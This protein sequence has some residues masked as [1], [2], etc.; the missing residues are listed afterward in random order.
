M[1]SKTRTATSSPLRL[2][3]NASPTSRRSHALNRGA[4]SSIEGYQRPEVI[5]HIDAI[6]QYIESEDAIVPSA[7]VI[8]FDDRVTFE[9]D[10]NATDVGYSTPGTIVIPIDPAAPES[11]RPGWIVDGQQRTAAIRDARVESFPISVVAFV[12]QSDAEQRAQFILVNAT[13]PLSKSLIYE[14]L[15]ATEG[16]LPEQLLRRQLPS[17][18]VERLNYDEDS[19]L[20]GM[21]NTPTTPDGIVKDNSML[22]M[23]ENSIT[24]GALYRFR[25]PETGEGDLDEMLTVL[26]PFWAA[27]RE[28]FPDAWGFTDSQVTPHARCRC[29]KPGLPYGCNCRSVLRRRFRPGG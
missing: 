11:D 8:A 15:P 22:R 19:P 1:F 20:A 29:R 16:E 4:T 23:L 2:T 9:P 27:V 24:D 6:R 26:K 14:L 25:N 13:K 21:I 12:A 7:L 3:A 10:P 18:L 5:R 17:R 28:T